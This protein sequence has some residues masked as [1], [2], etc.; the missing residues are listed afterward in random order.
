MKLAFDYTLLVQFCQ[1]LVLLVI[2]HFFVFKPVLRALSKRQETVRSL[3]ENA[4]SGAQGVES[5]KAAYEEGLKE[6]KVPIIAE[7]ESA[8]RESHLASVKVIE[9]AR[10]DLTEELWKVKDTVKKEAAQTMEHLLTRS[11]AFVGEI[12]QKIMRGG[13]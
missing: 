10:Q 13:A 8:L 3:A 12:V 4:Q 6:R 2:L 1:L 9:E 11:E 7:R 5:L